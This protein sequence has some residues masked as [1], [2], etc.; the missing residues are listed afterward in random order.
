MSYVAS[1]VARR[2]LLRQPI[3]TPA[4]RRHASSKIEEAGLRDGPRRDPEL[5]V[6]LAVMA[7]AAGIVGWYFGRKPTSVTSQSNVRIG[8][9]AMPWEMEEK[10]A[11]GA[12]GSFKYQY[13]PHGDQSKPLQNAPSA[14]N[15]V[16]IPNVTLPKDLHDRFNKYGKDDY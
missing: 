9:S 10:E 7:G 12:K 4:V 3:R 5:Y 15:E 14:L 13:H 16:I 8:Q 6:L 11:E 1:S 2:A